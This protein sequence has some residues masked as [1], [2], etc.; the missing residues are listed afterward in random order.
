MH[1]LR[2]AEPVGIVLLS[3]CAVEAVSPGSASDLP[4]LT[5]SMA[6]AAQ[7]WPEAFGSSWDA[8]EPL[9]GVRKGSRSHTMTWYAPHYSAGS[10]SAV[11]FFTG[12]N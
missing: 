2:C 10:A 5:A 7:G 3:R 4:T 8:R 6:C 1:P 12:Y 11:S 9:S